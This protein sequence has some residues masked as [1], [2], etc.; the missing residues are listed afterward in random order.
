MKIFAFK[1]RG[2][3][4]PPFYFYVVF[5]VSFMKDTEGLST[6]EKQLKN[7]QGSVGARSGKY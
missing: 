3:V 5:F 4:I 1:T 6:F 7:N 2:D